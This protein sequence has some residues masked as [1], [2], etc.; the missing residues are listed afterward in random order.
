MEF[1][2]VSFEEACILLLC[3]FLYTQ[4][5]REENEYLVTRRANYGRCVSEFGRST[6][7]SPFPSL[8]CSLVGH[9]TDFGQWDV[10]RSNVGLIGGSG[11]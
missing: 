1:E 4:R 8:P 7:A 5:K 2:V 10:S 9:V 6:D 11:S 3:S